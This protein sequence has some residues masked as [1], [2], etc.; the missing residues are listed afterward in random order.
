MRDLAADEVEI[1]AEGDRQHAE[2]RGHRRQHHRPRALAAGLQDRLVGALP[3]A[4]QPVVG[5]DQH[6]V[7]VHDHAGIGD[8][9]DAGHHHAERLAHDHQAEQHADGRQHDRGQHQHRPR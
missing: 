6:D 9:A 5:V 4:P 7:V 1:D 2:D 3:F 8:D